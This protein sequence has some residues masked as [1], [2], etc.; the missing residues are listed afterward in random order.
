[1]GLGFEHEG[2]GVFLV[3][4]VG[5]GAVGGVVDVGGGGDGFEF[6]A[7]G[8]VEAFGGLQRVGAGQKLIVGDGRNGHVGLT[9][10][11]LHVGF[12]THDK[13]E[14]S[15]VDDR[16]IVEIA[17]GPGAVVEAGRLDVEVFVGKVFGFDGEGFL[18]F[19]MDLY[20]VELGSA[21]GKLWIAGT[22]LIDAH[23]AEHIPGR[24]LSAV[25]VAA[26]AVG[27][28]VIERGEYLMNELL[29]FVG[30]ANIIEQVGHVVAGF[31]AVGILS[32]KAGDVGLFAAR[33]RLFGAEKL[34]EFGCQR[35]FAAIELHQ[36]AD[37]VRHEETVLPGVGLGVGE[38]YLGG[39]EGGLPC[40]VHFGTHELGGLVEDVLIGLRLDDVGFVVGLVARHLRQH[41]DAPVVVGIF[42]GFGNGFVFFV[43][44]HI[45]VFVHEGQT[46]VVVFGAGFH[47]GDRLLH[48]IVADAF[49]VGIEHDGNGMVAYHAVGFVGRELPNG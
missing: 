40:T 36:P 47:G 35:H 5:L 46:E 8:V 42:E 39:I 27:I 14:G 23:S 21:D 10:T 17:S 18:V 3:V 20:F 2:L 31:V 16:I 6:D 48:V 26:E 41:G 49:G 32:D 15:A 13:L 7:D 1:M 29:G 28:V 24:H 12:G 4:F 25:F 34:V 33:E 9:G 22:H 38:G 19:E 37:I 30:L 43:A 45:A 44:G 11:P